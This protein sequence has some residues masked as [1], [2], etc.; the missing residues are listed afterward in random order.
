MVGDGG[1]NILRPYS[2]THLWGLFAIYGI[3]A[4]VAYFEPHND[5]KNRLYIPK[6]YLLSIYTKKVSYSTKGYDI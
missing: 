2:N 1:R 4:P 5:V 6:F 3:S